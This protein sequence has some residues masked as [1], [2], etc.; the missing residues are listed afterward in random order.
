MPRNMYQYGAK[1]T[2][3]DSSENQ[4]EQA[5][6]LAADNKMD[7]RFLTCKAEN[8][9]FEEDTL[10]GRNHLFR[11]DMSKKLNLFFSESFKPDSSNAKV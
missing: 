7:I 5:K 11:P 9:D 2:G 8:I 6:K 4:I 3:I 1:W 10:Q